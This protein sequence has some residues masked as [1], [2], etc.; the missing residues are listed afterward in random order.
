MEGRGISGEGQ[1]ERLVEGREGGGA[2]RVGKREGKE[3][4]WRNKRMVK[5]RQGKEGEE[6]QDWEEEGEEE[7][8]KNKRMVK[9]RQG[10]GEKGRG[11]EGLGRKQGKGLVTEMA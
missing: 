3:E 5:G 1:G 6:G 8:W 2:V 10:K 9:E 4:R 11:R 7:R